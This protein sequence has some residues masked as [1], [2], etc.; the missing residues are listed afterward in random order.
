MEAILSAT[1][2]PAEILGQDTNMG[3][4]E[5]GKKADLIILDADPLQD[6]RHTRRIQ[7]VIKGGRIFRSM[8]KR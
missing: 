3:T 4:L 7:R 1:L 5:Q 2:R 8:E 6:I